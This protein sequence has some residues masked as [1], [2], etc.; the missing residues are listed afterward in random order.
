M[1]VDFDWDRN[2]DMLAII[3]DSSTSFYVWESES[4][5]ILQHKTLFKYDLLFNS[6][7]YLETI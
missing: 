4:S 7:N 3:D 6:L 5:R 1:A 2:G